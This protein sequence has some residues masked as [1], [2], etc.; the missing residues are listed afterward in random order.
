MALAFI[1]SLGTA[2]SAA[3]PRKADLASGIVNTSYQVGSALGLAAMTALA[4]AHG[5]DRLGNPP[6]LT[7]GYSAALLGAAAT[8]AAGPSSP[9]SPSPAATRPQPPQKPTPHQQPDE[10]PLLSHGLR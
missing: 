5:A 4:T 8:A 9:R 2:L 3:R 10:P 1:P 6:A 7:N